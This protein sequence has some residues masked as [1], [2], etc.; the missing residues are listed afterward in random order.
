MLIVVVS[1]ETMSYGV[2]CQQFV[3]RNSDLSSHE[4]Q[5]SVDVA[6]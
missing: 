5:H 1:R 2:V 3:F 4:Y 6:W